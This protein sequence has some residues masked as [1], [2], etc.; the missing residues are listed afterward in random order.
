M[1][2]NSHRHK[3]RKTMINTVECLIVFIVSIIVTILTVPLAKKTAILFGAIDYPSARR[4]NMI[5][6]PRLG[7]L[8][9]F[10]GMAA[11][12]LTA[13][14]GTEFFGWNNPFISHNGQHI[15]YWGVLFG[16]VL[17]FLVGIIDDI[18][19]LKAKIKFGGQLIAATIVTFSGVLLSSIHNP[20]GAGYIEFGLLSYPL[21]IFYL[22][23]FANI[24]NLI[25][26]LDGLAAGITGIS[27]ST[28]LIF[29]VLQARP[30]AIIF[31]LILIGACIGFLKWNYH[32]A[33]IFMGD[34][35]SL[36]LGFTLGII[37]LIATARSTLFVSLLVPILAAG[38]PIL[39][40]MFAII[41]R[42][43]EHR[44]IDE[45]DKGHI[46]HKLM[47]A[48]FSQKNTVLIMWAWTAMLSA[49][50]VIITGADNTLRIIFSIIVIAVT[51]YGV[52]KLHLF[53]DVLRHHF[54]PR[55]HII[56]K[57]KAE[58]VTAAHVNDTGNN[59]DTDDS[60]DSGRDTSDRNPSRSDGDGVRDDIIADN[61]QNR[62]TS[63]TGDTSDDK[64]DTDDTDDSNNK[65]A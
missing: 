37:S 28:I 61:T 40:T 42:K 11:G 60:N 7:G 46:H 52:I 44:P 8:A 65:V 18:F 33:S 19:D 50:A 48:G 54:I 56:T 24:I 27:A 62:I 15:N 32:P 55:P 59:R 26:G 1:H 36:L 41:R 34:S 47:K 6:T 13:Y 29:A 38:V 35:G 5:A 30:D 14:L 23:A 64:G 21:T 25:D 49:C 4:V 2:Q 16:I 51:S 43:R 22:V 31:S 57:E 53:G 45:A 3:E 63:D 39:D 10:L 9:M 58:Q 17:M 12:L 20:V